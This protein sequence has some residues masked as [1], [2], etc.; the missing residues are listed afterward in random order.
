[1]VIVLSR[2]LTSD[3]EIVSSPTAGMIGSGFSRSL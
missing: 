3:R 1:M 2:R